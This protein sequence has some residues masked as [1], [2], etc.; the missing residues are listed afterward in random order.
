[1]TCL[2]RNLCQVCPR[3]YKGRLSERVNEGISESVFSFNPHGE[4]ACSLSSEK[5]VQLSN[6]QNDGRPIIISANF[7]TFVALEGRS[8]LL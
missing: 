7:L 1:M 4:T 5:P 2:K 3:S 6:I 8:I